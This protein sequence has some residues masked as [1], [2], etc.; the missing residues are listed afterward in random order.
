MRQTRAGQ[1]R[2][3]DKR[4]G[5]ST[6]IALTREPLRY[7]ILNIYDVVSLVNFIKQSELIL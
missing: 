7:A 3:L 5:R 4:L 2:G 1:R 6:I